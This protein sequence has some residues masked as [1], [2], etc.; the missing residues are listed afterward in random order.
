MQK[1]IEKHI[2]L[3]EDSAWEFKSVKVPGQKVTDP[4]TKD[5]ADE[6]AAAANT[7]GT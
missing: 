1:T 3:G 5:L 2:L 7:T 4:D 6:F